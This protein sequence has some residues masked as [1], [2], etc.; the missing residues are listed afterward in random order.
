MQARTQSQAGSSGVVKHPQILKAIMISGLLACAIISGN[1]AAL[2]V[3]DPAAM[4]TQIREFGIQLT[5]WQ[6]T[7]EN[8]RQ[9]LISLGGLSFA[10]TKLTQQSDRFQEVDPDFGLND[11]CRKKNGD[12][13]MGSISS[14]FTPNSDDE[15]LGQQ[16][17]I[18]RRIVRAENLKYNET[19]SFLNN[20]RE[21]QGDLRRLD[22]RRTSVGNEQGRLQAINYDIQRYQQNSKMD[23]DNWQAMMTAYDSYIGQLNKY[24]Q[25]LANRALR[26][27]QPDV[28]STI[29]QGAVLKEVLR[30][31][32]R[33]YADKQ[34]E[35]KPRK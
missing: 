20:L 19:I 1:A 35:S 10:D 32:Q 28:F 18:C 34:A 25:R 13:L 23:L 4:A 33:E 2:I 27:K 31:K 11:A 29:V 26:G 5:R 14:M 16:L 15:I 24:Q 21:R 3:H 7:A 6:Q 30:E 9:Q 12:G 22:S 8:Y 17:E